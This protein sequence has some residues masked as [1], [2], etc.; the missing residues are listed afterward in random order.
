MPSIRSGTDRLGSLYTDVLTWTQLGVFLTPAVGKNINECK[1]N[2]L[3]HLA[4]FS[5]SWHTSPCHYRGLKFIR[6]SCLTSLLCIGLLA[7]QEDIWRKR[8]ERPALYP[9]PPLNSALKPIPR[10][11]VY[12]FLEMKIPSVTVGVSAPSQH[13]RRTPI[14]YVLI[15]PLNPQLWPIPRLNSRG[16]SAATKPDTTS[17]AVFSLGRG[18]RHPNPDLAHQN[19]AQQS[20]QLQGVQVDVERQTHLDSSEHAYESLRNTMNICV[21]D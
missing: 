1:T 18:P 9:P 7:G 6:I 13:P 21:L 16:S 14:L 2:F 5:L 8:R 17:S 15:A 11:Q 4:G 12:S 20:F 19:D 3:G 10:F